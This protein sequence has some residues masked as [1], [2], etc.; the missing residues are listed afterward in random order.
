MQ[1]NG[2][3]PV[4]VMLVAPQI[5]CWALQEL[6]KPSSRLR[7]VGTS[8][9]LVAARQDVQSCKPDLIVVDID[10]HVDGA[11]L[12]EFVS[13]NGTGRVIALTGDA[14]RDQLDDAVLA[15]LQ[16]II[17]KSEPPGVLL[18]AMEKVSQ[19]ELWIDRGATGRLFMHLIRTKATERADPARARIAL[20]TSRERQA[21]AALAADT[22][23][24]AKV[25]ASRLNMSEHTLRNHFTSIYSKLELTNRLDLYAFARRHHLDRPDEVTASS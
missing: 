5:L 1:V 23:A 13:S 7:L 22:A 15:G 25:I 21:I 2:D 20:L 4:R 10:D 9:D 14:G 3:T 6:M 18:T 16:G 12:V 24:P 17:R 19:G 11:A 8:P